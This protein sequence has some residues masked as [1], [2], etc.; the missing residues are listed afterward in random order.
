MA[1]SKYFKNIFYILAVFLV[2]C[3]AAKKNLVSQSVNLTDLKFSVEEAPEWSNLFKRTNGWYG[4]DGIFLIP[5]DGKE[6]VAASDTSKSLI[7][8]SDSMFGDTEDG[9]PITAANMLHNTVA[10]LDGDK[11]NKDKIKFYWDTDSAGHPH[12]VFIP[13]SPSTQAGDYYWL[14]DGFVNTAKDNTTYIF[15]YKM[16]NLDPKND[17]SFTVT[18]TNLISIAAG[19]TPPFKNQKQIETPLRFAGKKGYDNGSFGA[20]IFANTKDAGVQNPDGYVY[21]YG[22]KDK[23]KNLI[24]ARVKPEDF[25]DFSQ[26][27]FW[28]GKTW[29]ADMQKVSAI[30]DSVSNELSVTP[31][32]D[33]RYLL[34]FQL[35][36]LSTIVAMRIGASPVGPFGPVIK[37]Y[38][39]PENAENKNYFPYNAKAHPSISK[40]GELLISYNV[41]AFD[42]WKEIN[43]NH[44]LYRPRFIRLKFE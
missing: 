18:K 19:S 9:T 42:Y 26:W 38:N 2:S 29:N 17:W 16:K 41:N 8:F 25:E 6:N 12:T 22:V 4:G 24:A 30:A 21:V 27:R 3:S 31:L 15:A 20:G 5:T 39:C 40:P 7:L 14:G 37:L 23:A 43:K 34:V 44:T 36:G 33:G 1:S 28:D 11:P 35:G 10:I 13:N 32:A